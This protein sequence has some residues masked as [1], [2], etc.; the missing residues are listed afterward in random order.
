MFV[1]NIDYMLY[2]VFLTL[3]LFGFLLMSSD[4]IRGIYDRLRNRI[5]NI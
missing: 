4:I 1:W 2:N 5:Y 3:G